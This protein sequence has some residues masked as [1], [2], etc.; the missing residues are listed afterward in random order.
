[1]KP[2]IAL[3]AALLA[4][5]AAQLPA[6][7]C[8]SGNRALVLSGGGARGLAHVGVLQVLDSV[9]YRPDYI[10]GTS[11]GSIMGALT[12]TGYDARQ[13]DSLVRALD[14][15]HLLSAPRPFSPRALGFTEPILVW[16]QGHGGLGIVSAATLDTRINARLN[17]ALLLG[18]LTAAGSFDSLPIP[19]GAVAT[20]LRT[21][22]RVVLSRGDLARAVR[23]SMSIPL[24]FYPQRI[25]GTALVD[26]GIVDNIPTAPARMRAASLTVVDISSEAADSVDINS[27]AAVASQLYELFLRET[28]DSVRA[29]ELFVRPDI[30]GIGLLDFAPETMTLAEQRGAE[31]ARRAVR[32]W[33]CRPAAR[34]HLQVPAGPFRLASFTINAPRESERAFLRR[35][36]GLVAGDTLDLARVRRAYHDMQRS[37]ERREIWLNPSRTDSGL[38]LDIAVTPPPVL[39]G[40]VGLAFD[41]DMGGRLSGALVDNALFGRPVNGSMAFALGRYQQS[42]TLGVRP[43][44]ASWNPVQPDLRLALQHEDVRNYDQ[45]GLELVSSDTHDYSATL[46]LQKVS[47]RWSVRAGALG[48]AWSDSSGTT[49]AGGAQLQVTTGNEAHRPMLM[50]DAATTNAW[51]RASLDG[52]VAAH[53]SRWT[54]SAAARAG[55]GHQLPQQLA[56]RLG[57]SRGFPGYSVYELRGDRELFGELAVEHRLV[58]PVRARVELAG[59]RMWHSQEPEAL[60]GARLSAVLGTPIGVLTFGYGGATTGRRSV[61]ARLGTWF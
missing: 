4:F 12:A 40:G 39:K 23:A 59:G 60:G 46:S 17:D 13:L 43:Q 1:M 6:Q 52:E 7:S 24:V 58:G 41:Y 44:P 48:G 56:L 5:A 37:A 51:S 29:D 38:H 3:A 20:A 15:A 11:I 19:F 55:A 42:L 31:A 22:D 18:N 16:E 47:E 54:L 9:G 8:P 53:V 21:R 36:F 28:D 49:N 34:P 50:L 27:M 57:G 35:E 14:V 30:S 45:D 33:S 10:V 25:D 61:F 2:R 32:G 26:G